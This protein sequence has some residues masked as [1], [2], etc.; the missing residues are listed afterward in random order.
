MKLPNRV[1]P[2]KMDFPRLIKFSIVGA[3]GAGINMGFLWVLTDFAG[4]FYLFSCM[5]AIEIAIIMQFMMNDRWTFKDR[6]TTHVGQF[7]KRILKSNL[8]RSGGS[9]VNIGILYFLTEYMGVYYLLS[10]IFGI[11]CAFLL[12]YIFESRFT[13]HIE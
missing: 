1:E 6:K 3:I 12:N 5:V 2:L 11:I 8:W 4:L 9:T 7:I 10:N 13:W